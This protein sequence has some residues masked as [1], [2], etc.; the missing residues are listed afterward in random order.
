MPRAHSFLPLFYII[1]YL[2]INGISL[3]AEAL[4]GWTRIYFSNIF[5]IVYIH[6]SIDGLIINSCFK[7]SYNTNTTYYYYMMNVFE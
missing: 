3:V 1:K 5:F 7:T 6:A 4:S 2:N